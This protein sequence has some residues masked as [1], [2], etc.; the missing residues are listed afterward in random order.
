M[1]VTSGTVNR[2]AKKGLSDDADNFLK[3][4]LSDHFFHR[5]ALLRIADLVVG[6]GDQEARGNHGVRIIRLEDVPRELPG[7]E[8]VVRGVCIQCGNNPVTVPPGV[9]PQFVAFETLAFSVTDDV[10][11]VS[12]PAFPVVGVGQVTFHESLPSGGV[13]VGKKTRHLGRRRRE[14]VEIKGES[15]YKDTSGGSR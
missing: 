5:G 15:S 6:T 12:S 11:P 3:F 14:A 2:E 4:V 13:I 9:W 1:I 8:A 10:E 7:A